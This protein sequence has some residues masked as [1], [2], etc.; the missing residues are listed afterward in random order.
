MTCAV[1]G[2]VWFLRAHQRQLPRTDLD[3]SA[4][5]TPTLEFTGGG[6]FGPLTYTAPL[7]RIRIWSDKMMISAPG[8]RA[9][10]TWEQV[11][12]VLPVRPLIPFGGAG[13]EFQLAGH[14]PLVF[15][16]GKAACAQ[17]LE[18]V[19]RHGVFVQRRG[20]LRV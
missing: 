10:A 5:P 7:V 15:W 12:T 6:R 16:G 17:I 8:S 14:E 19:E 1:G 11:R 4:L 2:W 3:M 13:V 20:E 9:S 18:E